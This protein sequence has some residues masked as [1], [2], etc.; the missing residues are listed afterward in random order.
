MFCQMNLFSCSPFVCRKASYCAGLHSKNK[1]NV[2]VR[3]KDIRVPSWIPRLSHTIL[4]N[5]K[6]YIVNKLLAAMAKNHMPP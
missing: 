2:Y 1:D 3:L 6:I 4:Q 5:T